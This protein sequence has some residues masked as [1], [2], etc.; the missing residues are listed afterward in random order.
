MGRAWFSLRVK[1]TSFI[2]RIW[3]KRVIKVERLRREIEMSPLLFDA[4][5]AH[6]ITR[7]RGLSPPVA[8]VTN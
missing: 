1:A 6:D 8:S 7:T 3:K 2:W 4:E 5:L